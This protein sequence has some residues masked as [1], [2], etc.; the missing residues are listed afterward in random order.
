MRTV[1]IALIGLSLTACV[2]NEGELD[3]SSVESAVTVLPVAGTWD[4]G[5]ISTV[6]GTCNVKFRQFEDGAFN[7]DSVSGSTFRVVPRDGTAP[8]TCTSNVNGGFTCPNRAAATISLL[9][10]V[11]ARITARATATG[12][13]STTRLV[14]G[15]QD[16][17]ITCVGSACPFIGPSPCG[18]VANFSAHKL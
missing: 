15:K 4:Y 18:Y 3:T 9:P 7:I 14:T 1:M 12:V 11:D 16:L 6:T 8:F 10:F 17:A 2:T 5:E 13:F